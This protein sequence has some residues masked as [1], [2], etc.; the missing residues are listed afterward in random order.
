MG[1]AA[2]DF[3]RVAPEVGALPPVDDAP[4][5]S[6][7]TAAA[8]P[9][10][11]RARTRPA[12]APAS[13]P[14]PAPEDD[15]GRLTDPYRR[16]LL[17]HC[18]AMLG[19]IHDAEDLVQET[20]LRAWRGYD[21]FGHRS[22]LRTWLYRIATNACLTAVRQRGRRPMPSGLGGPSPDPERLPAARPEIPW[23]QPFPDAL[24]D[25][26]GEIDPAAI[27]TGRT[28]VRLALAAALQHLP[29]RQRAA[30]ILRDVLGWRSGEVADVLETTPAAVNSALQRA[31]AVIGRLAPAEDQVAEPSDGARRRL[32]DQWV[33]ALEAA[34]VP[35]V[36]G[37]LTEDAIWEM[38][39]WEAWFVGRERIGRL[40]R[41]Q[42]PAGPYESRLLLTR[43]NG[44]PTAAVYIHGQ[45]FSL[46]MLTLSG[47]RVSRVATFF[48]PELFP[49]CGLPAALEMSH[50]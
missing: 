6:P 18:Y 32:L 25:D 17:A 50:S 39:P 35:A 11:S 46:Q 45:A 2:E 1:P 4:S 21:G 22:S 29:P 3:T 37:L 20:Y 9:G 12:P 28:R 48:T 49:A 24:A 14:A 43:L 10:T 8:A 33:A 13:A 26:A 7:R 19:S 41:S 36:L 31:R 38:P 16:E 40:M 47:E 44:Q 42:C 30:L 34:D 5:S 27:V 15:F 23:L